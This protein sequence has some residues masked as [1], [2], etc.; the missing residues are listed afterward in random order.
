MWQ[1]CLWLVALVAFTGCGGATRFVRLDTGQGAPV[2][3]VPRQDGAGPIELDE[4]E[5]KEAL[6]QLARSVRTSPRPREAARRLFGV[7]SRN[8]PFVVE[9]VGRRATSAGALPAAESPSPEVE[10]TRSYLL[11]CGRT[12]RHGDCL[13]LLTESPTVTGEAR[14]ALALAL[15][16]AAVMDEL[17]QAVQGMPNPEAVME[18]VLWTAFTYALLWTVPEPA[19]KGVAAVLTA[20]LIIYV[21][22]DT[23]H[24]LIRGFRQLM[25]ESGQAVTFDELRDAGERFGKV[26]G[27]NAARAFLML[28]TAAI[29]NTAATLGMTARGL[30]GAAQAAV[31]AEARVGVTYSGVGQVESVA[32]AAEG[33]TFGLAPGAV[34]MSSRGT[35]GSGGASTGYREWQTHSGMYKGRG[36]AGPNKE[37]HH[38]V[39]QTEGNVR[40]FGPTAIHNTE[41]VIA[42]DKTLHDLLSAFYSKKR[43]RLTLSDDL[44]IREWLS[45]QS[46]QAQRDFGLLAIENIKKG[47][48]R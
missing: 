48:W 29:G 39:E 13:A 22:V 41:N 9:V 19:T 15:S 30:P 23:F 46:Y 21:G 1:R 42:L 5:V 37:W 14:F 7:D 36:S 11:W 2:I 8:R 3:H 17:W 35:R 44:T 25:A 45:T 38:I 24:Q 28:A 31:S 40:R 34:A 6:T 43:P 10:L 32:V 26:M 18:A 47:I 4:E 16:K 27:R 20:S 12:G 33:I